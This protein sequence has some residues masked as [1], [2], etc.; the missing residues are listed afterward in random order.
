MSR[1]NAKKKW[2]KIFCFHYLPTYCRHVKRGTKYGKKT[3]DGLTVSIL[4]SFFS[5]RVDGLSGFKGSRD[6]GF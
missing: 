5:K 6:R 4:K 2:V 3:G 1:K